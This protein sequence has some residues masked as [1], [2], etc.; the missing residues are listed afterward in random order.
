MERWGLLVFVGILA[1]VGY[2]GTTF[3][4][5]DTATQSAS[6]N[7]VTAL[8]S[9]NFTGNQSDT[10]KISSQAFEHNQAIP[11]LY[12]C[13]GSDVSPRPRAPSFLDVCFRWP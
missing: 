10:M 5:P 6:V 13:D 12:T 11:A 8:D 7:Y 4:E 3:R 2:W 1:V 9:H